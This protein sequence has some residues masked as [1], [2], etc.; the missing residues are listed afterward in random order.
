MP[1]LTKPRVQ[2]KKNNSFFSNEITVNVVEFGW[3]FFC[4]LSLCTAVILQNQISLE[5]TMHQSAQNP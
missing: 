4:Y 2:K 3:D 5:D 1:M